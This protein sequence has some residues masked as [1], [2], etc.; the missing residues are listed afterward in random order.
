MCFETL[1]LLLALLPL[2]STKRHHF[3][4]LAPPSCAECRRAIRCIPLPC[5]RGRLQRRSY[6]RCML[7]PGLELGSDLDPRD[8]TVDR[9]LPM[10]QVNLPSWIPWEHCSSIAQEQDADS[11]AAF[12]RRRPDKK[13]FTEQAARSE[14]ASHVE[15]Y[16][17]IHFGML[18]RG[19]AG[20]LSFNWRI[21]RLI[22]SA[23][24]TA[25][26]PSPR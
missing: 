23:R 6:A 21:R 7:L 20:V 5:L 2:G 8:V 10:L 15:N 1:L 25:A 4:R 12:R 18:R 19:F 22:I 14:L 9:C 3:G 13:M 11:L 16:N 17:L 26:A 24:W